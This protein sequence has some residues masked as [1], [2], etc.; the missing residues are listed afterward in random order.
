M[1]KNGEHQNARARMLANAQCSKCMPTL[2]AGVWGFE[3]NEMVI[4]SNVISGKTRM[5]SPVY[6]FF[7][8]P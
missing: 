2:C 7:V 8:A 6:R 5:L 3:K 4:I 1:D